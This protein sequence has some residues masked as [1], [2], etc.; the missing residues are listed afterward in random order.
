MNVHSMGTLTPRTVGMNHIDRGSTC[1]SYRSPPS[2]S[3]CFSYDRY[4]SYPLSNRGAYEN[5][6]NLI[7][8][9]FHQRRLDDVNSE[10]IPPQIHFSKWSNSNHGSTNG[11]GHRSSSLSPKPAE[12][13]V[14]L[15][16]R[17]PTPQVS[18]STPTTH[19][20]ILK[21]QKAPSDV[22]GDSPRGVFYGQSKGFWDTVDLNNGGEFN[23]SCNS[24]ASSNV[25]GD[26][27][28]RK[29]VR[30]ADGNPTVSSRNMQGSYDGV[31]GTFS[32]TNDSQAQGIYEWEPDDFYNSIRITGDL[33]KPPRPP[34]LRQSMRSER[35]ITTDGQSLARNLRLVSNL[36]EGSVPASPS[37]PLRNTESPL[38]VMD[39]NYANYESIYRS[40]RFSDSS[41]GDVEKIDSQRLDALMRPYMTSANEDVRSPPN[42]SVGVATSSMPIYRTEVVHNPFDAGTYV[43]QQKNSLTINEILTTPL[44]QSA[45]GSPPLQTVSSSNPQFI[46]TVKPTPMGSDID[47]ASDNIEFSASFDDATLKPHSLLNLSS[48]T[49]L[50]PQTFRRMQGN[51]SNTVSTVVSGNRAAVPTR[52]MTSR[53]L[54]EVQQGPIM[55]QPLTKRHQPLRVDVNQ[56]PSQLNGKSVT[57]NL[58]GPP[59]TDGPRRRGLQEN[60]QIPSVA[61]ERKTGSLDRDGIWRPNRNLNGTAAANAGNTSP[62]AHGLGYPPSPYLTDLLN[63]SI[64]DSAGFPRPDRRRT[65]NTSRLFPS[66][67]SF[68]GGG[69]GVEVPI[70]VLPPSVVNSNN[71]YAAPLT[72]SYNS[73]TFRHGPSSPN[74]NGI[75][76]GNLPIRKL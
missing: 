69:G 22:G 44:S 32:R 48:S 62:T 25:A 14:Q 36:D 26:S 5:D 63:G 38:A 46:Y 35:R 13:A 37:T 50:T 61:A 58:Q 52:A 47:E 56:A 27:T 23:D 41:L 70:V 16:Y 12:P 45:P 8:S 55:T 29:T 60:S 21:G 7:S 64:V 73:T 43:G 19:R 42:G 30:F 4:G 24:I 1:S 20:G 2:S 57:S 72:P 40:R 11:R 76:R 67:A 6:I 39:D 9:K 51:P 33:H 75:R 74:S 3:S 28:S 49:P 18:S 59:F 68:G 31:R 15:S 65:L 71:P 17:P 53:K 54:T 34:K 10:M 66:V